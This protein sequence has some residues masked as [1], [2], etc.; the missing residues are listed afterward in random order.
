MGELGIGEVPV[1][2]GGIVPP[3][4][5]RRLMAAGVARVYTPKDYALN[6]IIADIV[7]L[8]DRASQAAA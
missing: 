6:T 3:K 2:V 8:V 1:V 5:A 7:A 4:D